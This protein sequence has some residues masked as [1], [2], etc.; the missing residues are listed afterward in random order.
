MR[1][2][3]RAPAIFYFIAMSS[4]KKNLN[5]AIVEVAADKQVEHSEIPLSG[6]RCRSAI[7][8]Y[9]RR[10][11]TSDS[12]SKIPL[13]GR[14]GKIDNPLWGFKFL[15]VVIKRSGIQTFFST[16][17]QAFM[18]HFL[19]LEHYYGK[20]RKIINR[21]FDPVVRPS[22][23]TQSF[24]PEALDGRLSTGGSRRVEFID[25]KTK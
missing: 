24:D 11:T 23:S 20:R 25:Y 12:R 17:V 10:R 21:S 5:W 4:T 8:D 14:C 7:V 16:T 3:K 2:R 19:S 22:R 6:R 15:V 13:A 18:P 1:F 9:A